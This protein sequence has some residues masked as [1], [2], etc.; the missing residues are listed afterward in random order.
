[1]PKLKDKIAGLSRS[2]SSQTTGLGRILAPVSLTSSKESLPSTAARS[3]KPDASN[4]ASAGKINGFAK[5][6]QGINF[7]KPSSDVTTTSQSGSE[8]GS[9]LKQTASGGVASALSGGFGLGSIGGLGSVV[10]SL[11]SLFGGGKKTP[12]PLTEFSLPNAVN[13]TVYVNSTGTVNYQ[14][15]V[16]RS[17][18]GANSSSGIYGGGAPRPRITASTSAPLSTGQTSNPTGSASWIQIQNSQIAQAVKTA[19]LNSSSLN[20]VIADI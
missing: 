13:Q 9:L 3:A 19:L 1:M 18:P 20:D 10:S 8:W 11:V 7:G 6:S 17:N 16:S 14:G 2:T 4:E 5:Y 15:N 12:T